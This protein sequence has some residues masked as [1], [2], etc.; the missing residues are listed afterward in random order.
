MTGRGAAPPGVPGGAA[1]ESGASLPLPPFPRR[2][3]SSRPSLAPSTHAVRFSV[4]FPIPVRSGPVNY[5]RTAHIST[6]SLVN[7]CSLQTK[8]GSLAILVP[9]RKRKS[10][11][12]TASVDATGS[13]G[14]ARPAGLRRGDGA[15]GDS[16]AAGH[17]GDGDRGRLDGSGRGH[18]P[19]LRGRAPLPEV[20]QGRDAGQGTAATAPRDVLTGDRQILLCW[21]K[22]RWYCDGPGCEQGTFTGRC[23]RPSPRPADRPAARLARRGRRR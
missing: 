9:T 16:R 20:R 2:F 6:N 18:R 4:G 5:A 8:S 23:R 12:G 11:K 19:R 17:R 22:T 14:P 21:R 7:Y 15:A 13:T 1:G 10:A 3:P